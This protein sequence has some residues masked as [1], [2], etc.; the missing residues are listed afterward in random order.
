MAIHHIK[1]PRVRVLYI[2]SSNHSLLS[3]CA[4]GVDKC[5][6]V[7][8][9]LEAVRFLLGSESVVEVGV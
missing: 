6:R 9:M 7:D 1:Q 3:F 5:S 4:D 8:G 2:G